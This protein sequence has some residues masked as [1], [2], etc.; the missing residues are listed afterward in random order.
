MVFKTVVDDKDD[1]D[2][3]GDGAKD[4][5]VHDGAGVS[6]TTITTDETTPLDKVDAEVVV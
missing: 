2:G 4:D 6:L 5:K 1:E 3:D